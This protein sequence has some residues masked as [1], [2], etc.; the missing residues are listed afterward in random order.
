MNRTELLSAQARRVRRAR[1]TV[2]R[3]GLEDYLWALLLA[4]ALGYLAIYLVGAA[5]R[6]GYPF[7]FDWLESASVQ[8]V[9]R[10]MDGVTLYV[11]PGLEYTPHFYPP[12]YFYVSAGVSYVVGTELVAARLVS[13]AASLGVF[14]LV[15]VLVSRETGDRRAGVLA[16]CVFAAMFGISSRWFDLARVDS[17]FLL[18]LLGAAV[19]VRL[20]TSTPGVAAGAICLVLACVT[21]QAALL[22]APALALYLWRRD[23]RQALIFGGLFAAAL[24]AVTLV[25]N[26][27]TDGWYRY[28]VFDLPREQDVWD[29]SMFWKFFTKD[30]FPPLSVSLLATVFFLGSR[31]TRE[32]GRASAVWFY[33]PLGLATLLG[34]WLSRAHIGGWLNVLLPIYLFLAIGFGLGVSEALKR[35]L[36]AGPRHAPLLR[37]FV[38]CACLLQFA[39]LFYEPLRQIPDSRDEAAGNEVVRAIQALPG[40]VYVP[41]H[42]EHAAK[43][44]KRTYAH[45]DALYAVLVAQPSKTRTE[46]EHRIAAALQG[47]CFDAVVLASDL[48]PQVLAN[49]DLSHAYG[50]RRRL[51]PPALAIPP[52]APWTAPNSVYHRKRGRPAATAQCRAA[53][54]R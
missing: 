15:Y 9:R 47:G 44:G 54:L 50:R 28:Y 3:Y 29:T 14:V 53:G 8:A 21:K 32:Q 22:I 39:L 12:L 49:F 25:A 11:E 45:G 30:L 18:L 19:L 20:S 31:S 43:A 51:L 6:I 52:I 4:V 17:L 38:Y 37:A 48:P 33:L 2:R 1:A 26:A 10:V 24:L 34:S 41:F 40:N 7:H 36:A 16:A 13:F 46:L 23:R 42:P 5:S 35:S 27:L